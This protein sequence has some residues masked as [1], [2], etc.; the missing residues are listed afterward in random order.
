MTAPYIPFDP[1][2]PFGLRKRLDPSLLNALRQPAD[3][4]SAGRPPLAPLP[5]IGPRK[6]ADTLT[7]APQS[8]FKRMMKALGKD[9]DQ[10]ITDTPWFGALWPMIK[11]TASDAAEF[12]KIALE[13]TGIVDAPP[14]GSP[15]R[16][17]RLIEKGLP[18]AAALYPTGRGAK[19][20]EEAIAAI[21]AAAPKGIVKAINEGERSIGTDAAGNTLT[22]RG[23][24]L[25]PS[26]P[27]LPES[28]TSEAETALTKPDAEGYVTTSRGRKIRSTAPLPRPD[29]IAERITSAAVRDALTGKVYP[30]AVHDLGV[31][32]WAAAGGDPMIPP[33]RGYM[34]NRDR[35]VQEDL[36][37]QLRWEDV[38]R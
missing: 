6:A 18:L 31:A 23:R 30:G 11:G 38:G 3:A 1:T 12:T 4:T 27:P 7:E 20:A 22:N 28:I 5:T 32:D 36:A 19:A 17:E 29:A 8:D 37:R 10:A 13:P 14:P 26:A 33:Q 25:R 9:V 15:S 34:T 21:D 16:G 2:D 35:F 24:S